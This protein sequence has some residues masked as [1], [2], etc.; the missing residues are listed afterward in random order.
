MHADN[1][2]GLVA[3]T[4]AGATKLTFSGTANTAVTDQGPLSFPAW[5]YDTAGP[6]NPPTYTQAIYEA[7]NAAVIN[8]NDPR[9]I[10]LC[11]I[12]ATGYFPQAITATFTGTIL[13]SGGQTVTKTQA[14][15]GYNNVTDVTFDSSWQP[16]SSLKITSNIPID[17]YAISYTL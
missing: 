14:V 1:L 3:G 13:G 12:A 6:S 7:N 16:L 4:C 17:V 15:M 8:V 5:N 2:H 11:G 10:H 9:G